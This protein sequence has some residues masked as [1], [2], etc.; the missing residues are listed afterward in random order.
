MALKVNLQHARLETNPAQN[1]RFHPQ[2]TARLAYSFY[3]NNGNNNSFYSSQALLLL[4]VYIANLPF[5]VCHGLVST[6]VPW[7]RVMSTTAYVTHR[8]LVLVPTCCSP[9][10]CRLPM[11]LLQ[12]ND[13]Q[14]WSFSQLA[15]DCGIQF[16]HLAKGSYQQQGE[17][18]GNP[19]ASYSIDMSC[20][21]TVVRTYNRMGTWMDFCFK[22]LSTFSFNKHRLR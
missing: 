17:V 1:Y 5:V 4:Y 7:L 14:Q 19:F 11:T 18:T 9:Q 21:A 12:Q 3:S 22:L 13:S 16:G 20:M 10:P 6:L 15:Q 8:L 2:P